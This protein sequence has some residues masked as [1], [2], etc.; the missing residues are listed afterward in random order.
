M[1]FA[2]AF[3][4]VNVSCSPPAKPAETMLPWPLHVHEVVVVELEEELVVELELEL[5][6]ELEVD[7]S[8]KVQAFSESLFG[9]LP[10][11]I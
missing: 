3:P 9:Q 6:L 5:E 10:A 4:M 7:I 1:H 11:S 2:M 8:Y